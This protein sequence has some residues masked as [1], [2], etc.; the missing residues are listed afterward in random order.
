MEHA[1]RILENAFIVCF[2]IVAWGWD[3]PADSP[4]K[5]LLDRCRPAIVWLGLW[6]TWSLFTSP[7][8]NNYRLFARFVA[9]DGSYEEELVYDPATLSRMLAFVAA[10]RRKLIETICSSDK[11][12]FFLR[13][14]FVAH[15]IR[16]R[17]AAGKPRPSSVSLIV[18]RTPI[19]AMGQTTTP[20]ASRSVLYPLPVAKP[21]QPKKPVVNV[22][23]PKKATPVAVPVPKPTSSG[24]VTARPLKAV[25][26]PTPTTSTTTKPV[27]A[28]KLASGGRR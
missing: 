4:L 16:E 14:A 22:A 6:H 25:P 20:K 17:V 9:A 1:I 13:S 12:Y 8:R 28:L 7:R 19:P 10:R 27:P 15:L 26:T 3:L 21:A 18:E 23:A 24:I 11:A 5:R 2:L